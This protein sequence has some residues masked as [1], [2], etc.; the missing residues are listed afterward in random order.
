MTLFRILEI[1]QSL[2]VNTLIYSL[3]CLYG[4]SGIHREQKQDVGGDHVRKLKIRG[5]ARHYPYHR[6]EATLTGNF[7]FVPSF[8]A[9]LDSYGH[10]ENGVNLG[11]DR[12]QAAWPD[13]VLCTS[14]YESSLWC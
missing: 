3:L 2:I 5:Q 7:P 1:S 4:L 12:L 11:S 9:V 14:A 10:S 6:F 13:P 8:Q